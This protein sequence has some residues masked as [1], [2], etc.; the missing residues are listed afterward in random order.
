M[1]INT[2]RPPITQKQLFERMGVL[3]DKLYHSG[4]NYIATIKVEK[5]GWSWIEKVVPEDNMK[6]LIGNLG[7]ILAIYVMKDEEK[8]PQHLCGGEFTCSLFHRRYTET[9]SEFLFVTERKTPYPYSLEEICKKFMI[10][11]T[12]ENQNKVKLSIER[13]IY[14]YK[15]RDDKKLSRCVTFETAKDLSEYKLNTLY[16]DIYG[17]DL[18]LQKLRHLAGKNISELT[19]EDTKVVS[20]YITINKR[21]VLLY[22]S[23]G[24][25]KLLV[26]E[27]PV[28]NTV[29]NQDLREILISSV[30][31]C[32]Y[33]SKEITLLND[34]YTE[35][36]LTF[37]AIVPLY[38]HRKD[39]I[40]ICCSL[41]NSKKTFKNNLEL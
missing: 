12:K 5:G 20:D 34:K 16:F 19:V 36:G 8:L 11:P 27:V 37:D 31:Q 3:K 32:K 6:E 41:C 21:P 9:E 29:S 33:C 14:S 30:S 15:A 35:T 26:V 4:N 1:S 2:E 23:P 10:E 40:M 38:G 39:N 22:K 17:E 18:E 7:A 24:D 28:Y 25:S 13:R